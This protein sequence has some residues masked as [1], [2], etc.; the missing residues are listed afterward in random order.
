[1]DNWINPRLKG[2]WT[3]HTWAFL[4]LWQ[5]IESLPPI[6]LK[7]NR[8]ERLFENV[9]IKT[10]IVHNFMS[11]KR[12]LFCFVDH[13]EA[14]GCARF[15]F[16]QKVTQ[17]IKSNALLWISWALGRVLKYDKNPVCLFLLRRP[18]NDVDLVWR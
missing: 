11:Q 17:N 18:T 4:E 7:C 8:Q 14:Y 1:M 15:R 10:K 16:G 13:F 12:Y 2:L 3:D 5:T 6:A 9:S